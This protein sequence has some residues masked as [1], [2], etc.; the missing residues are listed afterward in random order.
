MNN[1]LNKPKLLIMLQFLS[2]S[3]LVQCALH[4][5]KRIR[6]LK[7]KVINGIMV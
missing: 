7:L 6:A 2:N 3:V 5:L 1:N 4:Y